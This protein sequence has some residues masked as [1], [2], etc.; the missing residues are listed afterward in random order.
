[1]KIIIDGP[2]YEVKNR[3]DKILYV[4]SIKPM[5]EYNCTILFK[6]YNEFFIPTEKYFN[7]EIF[8]KIFTYTNNKVS[9]DVLD[10]FNNLNTE[11]IELITDSKYWY[12]VH[13]R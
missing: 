11:E 7:K 9:Q 6:N 4:C 8:K 10:M 1:M 12:D 5:C 13:L 3:T 2:I